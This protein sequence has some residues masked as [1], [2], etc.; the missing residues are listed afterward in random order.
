M[1]DCWNG[2]SFRA[3]VSGRRQR[4]EDG[5][6]PVP[7]E[8]FVDSPVLLLAVGA[9]VAGHLQNVNETIGELKINLNE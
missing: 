6:P 3:L 8:H 5:P 2:S 7:A 9:T 1:N 4:E